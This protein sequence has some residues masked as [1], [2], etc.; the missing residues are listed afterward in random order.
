MRR[1]CYF[2]SGRHL[3]LQ[4]VNLLLACN[5]LRLQAVVEGILLANLAQKITDKH[6][7]M[8][9]YCMGCVSPQ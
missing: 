3:V 8:I 5:H 4:V 6:M 7:G 9:V 1:I 2:V